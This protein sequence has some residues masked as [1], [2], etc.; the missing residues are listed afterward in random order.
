MSV[1]LEVSDEMKESLQTLENI[2][3]SIKKDISTKSKDTEELN[4]K[5]KEGQN[6]LTLL[7]SELTSLPASYKS[8][9]NLDKI[10]TSLNELHTSINNK[11]IYKAKEQNADDEANHTLIVKSKETDSIITTKSHKVRRIV[12]SVK[13]SFIAVCLAFFII[14]VI[15]LISN[16]LK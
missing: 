11:S 16:F 9:I 5:I 14:S 4:E 10:E 6:E 7:K 2:I 3:A 12:L 13:N 1:K 15:L 8:K